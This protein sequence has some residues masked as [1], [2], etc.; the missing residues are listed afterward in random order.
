[1]IKLKADL[2]KGKLDIAEFRIVSSTLRQECRRIRWKLSADGKIVS[3]KKIERIEKGE[4][5]VFFA[6]H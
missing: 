5:V 3:N 4:N 6:L 1:L 2:I